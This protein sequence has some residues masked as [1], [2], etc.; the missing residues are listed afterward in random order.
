MR[1]IGEV[2]Q[3]LLDKW[4]REWFGLW[5]GHRS[6]RM[7][8]GHGVFLEKPG[9]SFI[10]SYYR[11]EPLEVMRGCLILA[12]RSGAS[13]RRARSC[14]ITLMHG[15]REEEQD[16]IRAEM[17]RKPQNEF[18]SCELESLKLWNSEKLADELLADFF[19]LRAEV[20]HGE[21]RRAA[22]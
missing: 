12:A 10:C 3:E 4:N 17:N 19:K 18:N 16:L 1:H 11:R 22:A 9:L 6:G 7:V 2:V 15:L 21:A 14:L 13:R 8:I 5:L 20:L